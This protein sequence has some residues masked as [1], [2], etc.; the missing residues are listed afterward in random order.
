MVDG[1]MELHGESSESFDDSALAL[2]LGVRVAAGEAGTLLLSVGQDL[3]NDLDEE[4]SIF[5]YVGWQL[6]F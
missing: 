5:G 6:M 1:M 4:A 3:H 2:N